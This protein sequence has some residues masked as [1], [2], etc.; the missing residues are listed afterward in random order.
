MRR[1]WKHKDRI[2]KQD[3]E[4]SEGNEESK[5]RAATEIQLKD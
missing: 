5:G 1:K 2:K 4:E 3:E